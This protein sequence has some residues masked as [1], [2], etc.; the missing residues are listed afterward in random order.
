M[1]NIFVQGAQNGAWNLDKVGD[2][3][4]EMGI[5]IKDLD[6]S[7]E[8]LTQ[9]G[10]DAEDVSSKFMKGGQDASDAFFKVFDALKN[11][12]DGTTRNTLA[13][14]IFGTMY[15]DLGEQA[16]FALSNVDGSIDSTIDKT[17]E[18]NGVNETTSSSFD[19]VSR[20][21]ENVKTTIAE[22]LLPV[23]E[24][25]IEKFADVIEKIASWVEDNPELTRT[26]LIIVGALGA[27]LAIIGPIISFLG[28]LTLAVMAFN[29]ATLPVTGTILLVIGAIAALIA[30]VTLVIVKWDEIVACWN[31]FCEWSKQLWSD[32]TSWITSKFTE[33]KDKTLAKIQE[34]KDGAVNKFIEIKTSVVNRIQEMKDGVVNKFNEIKNNIATTID[35]IKMEYLHGQVM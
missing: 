31:S 20:M 32:F 3:I 14:E 35:N 10:L 7:G 21:V 2:A 11:V 9:L 13:T 18:L 19:R 1:F 33:I 30:I 4:K 26:I 6:S 24:P 22:Q 8:A 27:F 34:M 16:T 25:L 15:E 5:Q 17:N 23:L 28:T 12:E 29:V